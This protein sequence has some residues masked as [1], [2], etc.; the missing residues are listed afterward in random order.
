MI[1]IPLL[2]S[3]SH[4]C[5]YLEQNVSHSAFVHPDML[6]N[7]SIYEQLIGQGFRRSGD[8]VYTPYCQHC[9]ACIPVRIPVMDFKPNRSQQRCTNKHINT[10]AIIK[11]A[12]F[13]QAHYEMYLRYQQ[14][15]HTEG[16]MADTSPEEYINF[17]SSSWCDTLFIEFSIN[18]ELAG[19]AV[20]D[21]FRNAWSAVYTFFEPKFS[22]YSLGVYA[23]LWQINN[24][25]QSNKE[26][27][28]LGYWI[29]ECR[30]MN[31][32]TNYQP[33]QFLINKRW[34]TKGN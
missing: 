32:K 8:E 5:S 7:N 11:P 15:R 9:S 27:L 33:L 30:K 19:I 29:E 24:C 25:I 28:Y 2:L 14:A 20:V 26:F 21:Q 22:N 13:E 16:S 12:K 4:P 3:R 6:M 18:N 31:Y 23:V 34:Q 10:Q 1:Q 17:L